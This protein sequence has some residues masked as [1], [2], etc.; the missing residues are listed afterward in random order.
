M[1]PDAPSELFNQP[2]PST[3]TMPSKQSTC[4]VGIDVGGKNTDWQANSTS[5][6]GS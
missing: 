5:Y 3:D 6:F 1:S 2:R 4:V